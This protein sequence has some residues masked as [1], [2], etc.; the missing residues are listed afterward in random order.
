MSDVAYVALTLLTVIVVQFGVIRALLASNKSLTN[1]VVAEDAHELRM[2]ESST[3][4]SRP[5]LNIPF[6]RNKPVPY[7]EDDDDLLPLGLSG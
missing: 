4:L 1:A 7:D 3:Q 6:V 5:A 2:L